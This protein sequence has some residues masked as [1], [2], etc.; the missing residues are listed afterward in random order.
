MDRVIYS[1]AREF[2]PKVISYLT[3]AGCI[4]RVLIYI[5]MPYAQKENTSSR[6][7]PLIYADLGT[8]PGKRPMAAPLS[9][10]DHVVYSTVN[11]NIN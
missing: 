3:S 8:A 2:K 10:H 5:T 1:D 11:S 9:T 6:E 4:M 7:K